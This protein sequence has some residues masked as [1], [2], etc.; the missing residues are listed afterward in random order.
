[1][2]PTTPTTPPALGEKCSRARKTPHSAPARERP[3]SGTSVPAATPRG[4]ASREVEKAKTNATKND[5]AE[6]ATDRFAA[7]LE[8][9]VLAKQ[10]VVTALE[11]YTAAIKVTATARRGS[12]APVSLGRARFSFRSVSLPKETKP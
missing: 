4:G 5:A 3:R 10:D 1:M 2:L 8:A 12:F 9:H 11:E 7:A 6:E